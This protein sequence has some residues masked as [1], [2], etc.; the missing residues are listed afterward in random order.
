MSESGPILALILLAWLLYRTISSIYCQGIWKYVI[1]GTISS[2]ILIAVHWGS[3]SSIS[4]VSSLLQGVG[5]SYIPRMVY[6]VGLGQLLL[7]AFG[8][9][10]SK[11]KALDEKWSL[12]MKTTAMLSAWSST[13][14]ILSG[15]QGS[16]IALASVIGGTFSG[17]ALVLNYI[18]S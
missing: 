4:S 10:F 11:E 13:I 3:E 6:T 17:R 16:L 15:Q 1:M 2:Y 14:I 12:I 18:A 8:Q 5:R 9:L 7:M